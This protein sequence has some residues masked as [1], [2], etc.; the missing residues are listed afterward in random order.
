MWRDPIGSSM[1]RVPCLA[2]AGV[3]MT[4]VATAMQVSSAMQMRR[5]GHTDL[6]VSECCIGGMTFGN[7]N[8]DADGA[9]QLS[10]AFDFGVNFIDTAESYPVPM[11]PGTQGASDRAIAKWM[12]T[13]KRPRDSVILSSKVCGY[14]DRYTW[15]RDSGEGTQLTKAQIHESVDKSLKRLGTDYLDVLTLHWP[16]RKVGLTAPASSEADETRSREEVPFEV[17]VE[18]IGELLAAG[19]IRHWGLSNENAEGVRAFSRV[20]SEL[21]VARPVCIQNAYSLLQRGDENELISGLGLDADEE[22]NESPISF[23]PCARLHASYALV[24]ARCPGPIPHERGPILCAHANS[25]LMVP[26]RLVWAEALRLGPC[27]PMPLPPLLAHRGALTSCRVPRS[28]STRLASLRR[29][30]EWQIR[31]VCSEASQRSEAITPAWARQWIRGELPQIC[32]ASSSRSLRGGRAQ[33]WNYTCTV[34]HCAV[35]FT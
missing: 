2:V 4:S 27:R 16:E 23:L 13:S 18:A 34:G 14:N 8:T 22:S 12:V 35:Q 29:R 19:K 5:L 26:L 20:C 21:S 28:S 10:L 31:C 11:E 9:A 30:A 6:L 33:A 25:H 3:M 24:V 7:Q 15:F 1:A 17:Q 32:G